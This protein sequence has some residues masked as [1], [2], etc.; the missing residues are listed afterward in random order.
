MSYQ[1]QYYQAYRKRLAASKRGYGKDQP[2]K[3]KYN[4]KRIEIDGQK[5]DSQAE[6]RYYYALKA[7]GI[8]NFK[9]QESFVILD[10]LKMNGKTRQKRVYKPDFTF[11]DNQGQLIKVVDVK[12]GQ[13][14]L[15]ESSSLRMRVFMDRYKIPVTVATLDKKTG[16]FTE[17]EI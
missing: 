1:S 8:T 3:Q 12:G 14:T 16:T 5:F 10:T 6:A 17:K 11:Y 2:K 13:A 15:T 9:T 7:Q 4:A